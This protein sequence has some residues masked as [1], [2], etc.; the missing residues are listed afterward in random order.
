VFLQGGVII[1]IQKVIV[2]K[3]TNTF[4]LLKSPISIIVAPSYSGRAIG[5]MVI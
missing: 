3:I 2:H 1:P 4:D 5:T